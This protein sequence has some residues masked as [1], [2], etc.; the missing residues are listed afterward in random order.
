MRTVVIGTGIAG[1]GAAY[2]L[3]RGGH[4]VELFEREPRPG[5]HTHTVPVEDAGRTLGIDTG[6]IVHNVRTYPN[7]VRLFEAIGFKQYPTF[8]RTIDRLL[9]PNGL[10]CI[11][12]IAI[13]DHRFERYRRG[14]DWIQRYMFPGSLLPSLTAIT[15]AA[16]RS[17]ELHVHAL[18]AIGVHYA[19]TLRDWRVRF[20][21]N[22]DAARPLGYDDRFV[23][24]WEFYLASCEAAFRTRSLRDIQ[25]VLTRSFNDGLHRHRAVRAI[26]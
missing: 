2:S 7:L 8:F 23:R 24:V 25:L 12:A 20:L 5:G 22:L 1:L 18:E 21:A 3:S 19:D 11:Q 16:T 10:V 9:A 26:G 15:C 13:P 17:S 6:F 4:D 14:E